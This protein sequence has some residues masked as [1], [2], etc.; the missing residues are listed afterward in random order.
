MGV[1]FHRQGYFT[2]VYWG[3]WIV[4]FFVKEYLAAQFHSN[5]KHKNILYLYIQV[6]VNARHSAARPFDGKQ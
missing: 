6:A 4:E 2:S 5:N 1:N 3:F